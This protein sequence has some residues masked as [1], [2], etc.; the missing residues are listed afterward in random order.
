MPPQLALACFPIG[1]NFSRACTPS[2]GRALSVVHILEGLLD[3]V[4]H[5][6]F[7]S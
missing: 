1:R 3:I 5:A 7:R 6:V 2:M 4:R